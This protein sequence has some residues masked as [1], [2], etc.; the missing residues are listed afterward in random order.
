MKTI[1]FT[2]VEFVT[3][4]MNAKQWPSY[5]KK[6]EIAFAGKSNVGKSSLL[7]HLTSKKIAYTS[8]KPGKTQTINFF[9]IDDRLSV[10]DLPGYGYSKVSKETKDKWSD[11]MEE[12]FLHRENLSLIL[13]LIDIRRDPTEEDRQFVE[14]CAHFR[15]PIA[16]LFTKSDTLKDSEVS[17]R[18][19]HLS[20][21][22]SPLTS[23]V[24]YLPYSIKGPHYR[25]ACIKHIYQYLHTS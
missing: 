7:N 5:H 20:K 21:V 19:Q 23:P 17:Q 2:K 18:M 14:F 6:V 10:V 15:K 9:L 25:I 11:S 22:L 4:A 12:F 3:S 24:F 13:L 1:D 8:S 16:F